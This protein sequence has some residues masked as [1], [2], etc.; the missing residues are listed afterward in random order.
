[1][2]WTQKFSFSRDPVILDLKLQ[3]ANFT[4]LKQELDAIRKNPLRKKLFFFDLNKKI[5]CFE[6]GFILSHELNN[7]FGIFLN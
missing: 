5:L 2:C 6:V 3:L 4:C 1:M 7:L